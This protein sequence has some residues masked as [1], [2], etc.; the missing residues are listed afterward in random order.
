MCSLS[1]HIL[2]SNFY[3][4]HY[5]S[6]CVHVDG[7]T[8]LKKEGLFNSSSI[9]S[10]FLITCIFHHLLFSDFSFSGTCVFLCKCVVCVVLCGLLHLFVWSLFPCYGIFI[11]CDKYFCLFLLCSAIHLLLCVSFATSVPAKNWG[12]VLYH[13][14]VRCSWIC[15]AFSLPFLL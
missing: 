8:L 11:F 13:C 10:D 1:P 6:E 9:C 4:K 5:I 14:S 3:V 15:L 7:V 2:A 12:Y